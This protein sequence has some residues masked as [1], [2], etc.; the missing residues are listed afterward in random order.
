MI[1]NTRSFTSMKKQ[2]K[3][4]ENLQ[5]VLSF[6]AIILDELVNFFKRVVKDEKDI[7]TGLKHYH[8]LTWLGS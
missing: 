1:T 4:Q 7:W 3:P 2:P 5:R 6:P 8:S